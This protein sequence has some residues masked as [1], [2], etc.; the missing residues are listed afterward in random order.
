MTKDSFI[1]SNRTD[2]KMKNEELAEMLNLFRRYIGN[3]I[4]GIYEDNIL[5]DRLVVCGAL[6]ENSKLSLDEIERIKNSAREEVNLLIGFE[7][8][9]QENIRKYSIY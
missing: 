8:L 7:Q 9:I 2:E 3:R 6:K 1:N 5:A 4:L